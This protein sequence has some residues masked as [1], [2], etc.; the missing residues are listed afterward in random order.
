MRGGSSMSLRRR[1][2][3]APDQFIL[4]QPPAFETVSQ[5][6]SWFESLTTNVLLDREFNHLP[7]RP[8][9][10]EGLLANCDAVSSH[11]MTKAR[12]STGQ[13]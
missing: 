10:V 9:L 5:H 6:R 1:R 13:S 8:E 2:N 4:C 12:L 11:G 3:M 7:V